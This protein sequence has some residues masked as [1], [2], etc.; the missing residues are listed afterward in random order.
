MVPEKFVT[1]IYDGKDNEKFNQYG[2]F[3]YYRGIFVDE[4]APRAPQC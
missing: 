3:I 2:L 1:V 4:I